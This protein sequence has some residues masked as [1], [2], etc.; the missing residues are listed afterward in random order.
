[1]VSAAMGSAIAGGGSILGS[2]LGAR[3]QK[4]A[5]D[6][7][8]A[9][10]IQQYNNEL[11]ANAAQQSLSKQML[12]AQLAPQQNARGDRT[13]YIPGLGYITTASETT[14]GLQSA[15]DAE[16]RN[17]LTG[18][19]LAA[20]D[21]E[22]KARER[23]GQEGAYADTLLDVLTRGPQHQASDI[24]GIIGNNDVSGINR[25]YDESEN[26][27]MQ[28]LMRRSGGG[29]M[30]AL[31]SVLDKSAQS[32]SRA[33]QDALGNARLQ[34]L[35]LTPEL[36]SKGQNSTA[37]LYN[38]MAGRAGGAPQ[39]QFNPTNAGDELANDTARRQ[40][41]APQAF[42]MAMNS[43]GNTPKLNYQPQANTGMADMIGGASNA[44]GAGVSNYAVQKQLADLLGNRQQSTSQGIF[45]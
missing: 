40:G 35:Q 41:M 19:A 25:S 22:G 29:A 39:Q 11:Q 21:Q 17:R 43:F 3:A 20:R 5:Q 34:A 37:N 42:G 12:Q 9:L 38:I 15:S 32:R 26:T 23:R 2:I 30:P 28:Q 18:D 6:Q 1:M 13:E 14:R 36:N 7:Q 45:G 10:A 27:M 4:Q 16:E 33:T 31:G 24:E 8:M 44:I